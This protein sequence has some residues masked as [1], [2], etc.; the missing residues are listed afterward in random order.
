VHLQIPWEQVTPARGSARVEAS[1]QAPTRLTP[2]S[3]RRGRGQSSTKGGSGFAEVYHAGEVA[4]RQALSRRIYDYLVE[5]TDWDLTLD[6]DDAD[7]I[8]ASR[9]TSRTK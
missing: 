2:K 5:H 1:Q 6:C 3:S 7:D 9:I 4:D 8:I